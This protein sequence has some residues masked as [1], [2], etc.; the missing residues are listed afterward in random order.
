MPCGATATNHCC[1]VGKA[2]VCEHFVPALVAAGLGCS[3]RTELGSWVAV[4]VDG[5]YP[6]DPAEMRCGDYPQPGV[7]CG[8]CG[9]TGG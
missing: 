7:T 3:L 6:F 5:R 1:W 8:E 2:G 4:Y 9:V